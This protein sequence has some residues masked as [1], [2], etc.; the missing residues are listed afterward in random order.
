VCIKNHGSRLGEYHAVCGN[1]RD[2]CG[3]RFTP[4]GGFLEELVRLNDTIVENPSVAD[5]DVEDVELL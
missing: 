4:E 2:S 5:N 3:L 1:C